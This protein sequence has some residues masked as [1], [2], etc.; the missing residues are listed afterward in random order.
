MSNKHGKQWTEDTEEPVH[1]PE[2]RAIQ[3]VT[4]QKRQVT[5]KIGCSQEYNHST[6][7][8]ENR[9][10]AQR[11]RENETRHNK[12]T[13]RADLEEQETTD[14]GLACALNRDVRVDGQ[15]RKSCA[16]KHAS[17]RTTPTKSG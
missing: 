2:T 6:Q 7:V 3:E 1:A 11:E 15:R 16:V 14:A 4:L 8:K 17:T 13:S 5:N 9:H 12:H 10:G